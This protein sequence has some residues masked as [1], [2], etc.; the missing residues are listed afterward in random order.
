MPKISELDV[1]TTPTGNEWMIV[2]K[3]GIT[4]KVA[5]SVL[6]QYAADYWAIQ[7]SITNNPPTGEVSEGSTDQ[8]DLYN[9]HHPV[10]QYQAVTDRSY[11]WVDALT[12][13]SVFIQRAKSVIPG[14]LNTAITNIIP[15]TTQFTNAQVSDMLT[16]ADGTITVGDWTLDVQYQEFTYGHT[17]ARG[18]HGGFKV[19]ITVTSYNG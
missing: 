7:A 8:S 16:D 10:A 4:S 12:Q 9:N 17:D 6:R 3:D 13:G 18:W 14:R 11:A 15:S 5:L 19:T 2:V 1:T